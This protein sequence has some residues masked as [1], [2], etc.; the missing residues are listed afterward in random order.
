MAVSTSDKRAF[1]EI[2]NCSSRGHVGK[3]VLD[4]YSKNRL[5]K[6]DVKAVWEISGKVEVQQSYFDGS[7]DIDLVA[8]GRDKNS[9]VTWEEAYDSLKMVI[10]S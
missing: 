1:T 6:E 3:L 4:K 9:K 8:G 2:G 7:V 5:I 10:K